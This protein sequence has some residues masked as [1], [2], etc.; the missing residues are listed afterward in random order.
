LSH[1]LNREPALSGKRQLHD[2]ALW[3]DFRQVARR[4]F[5]QQAAVQERQR[6]ARLC[7]RGQWLRDRFD[8]V[9]QKMDRLAPPELRGAPLIMDENEASRPVYQPM[10]RR[11]RLVTLP[12]SLP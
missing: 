9:F 4:F 10:R 8:E 5:Q 1:E 12:R 7:R 3:P 11:L 2:K 6:Q